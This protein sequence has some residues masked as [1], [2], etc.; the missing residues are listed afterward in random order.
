MAKKSAWKARVQFIAEGQASAFSIEKRFLWSVL[1]GSFNGTDIRTKGL[2]HASPEHYLPLSYASSSS[3]PVSWY[4]EQAVLHVC[5]L[6][7]QATSYP[8]S[9]LC[10]LK[11]WLSQSKA[12]NRMSDYWL[13]SLR[14]KAV[15]LRRYYGSNQASWSSSTNE[16]KFFCTE[17]LQIQERKVSLSGQPERILLV[18]VVTWL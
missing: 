6:S 3:H 16:V 5:F 2:H 18:S 9:V 17:W 11:E 4:R 10:C 7:T 13:L 12:E 14:S 15:N 8:Y 1:L